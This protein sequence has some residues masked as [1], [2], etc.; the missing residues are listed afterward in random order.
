MAA[1]DRF[2]GSVLVRAGGRALLE[3]GAGLADRSQRH[4]G[5][6]RTR[7]ALASLSKTF[8]AMAVLS[9]VR[10]G[11][12]DPVTGWPTCCLQLDD[13]G[14][15]SAEVTVHQLLTH[16]SGIGDYA[17]EDEDVADHVED[18]GSLWHDLPTYRMERPDDYLP[19]YADTPRSRSRAAPSTTATPAT[20]CSAR[21]WRS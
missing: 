14:R 20:S 16:T 10:A 2:S 5:D 13:P 19:M 4:T 17:E 8:T 3:C 6:A 1:D 11:M 9:C 21:C 18:Y 7:F 12:L 15:W